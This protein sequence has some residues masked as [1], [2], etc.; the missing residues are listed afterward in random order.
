MALFCASVHVGPSRVLHSNFQSSD[1]GV[2]I[3]SDQSHLQDM[4][5]LIICL[6]M[7]N[8]YA[9]DPGF[10]G[11]QR[12]IDL[13]SAARPTQVLPTMAHNGSCGQ[14]FLNLAAGG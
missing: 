5:S 8:A 13:H 12:A 6:C 2:G 3:D 14:V 4:R 11:E 9:P 1:A 10:E 7:G